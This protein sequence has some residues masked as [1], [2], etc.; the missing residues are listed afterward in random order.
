SLIIVDRRRR[1]WRPKVYASVIAGWIPV[2]FYLPFIWAQKGGTAWMGR[3]G[4]S[5]ILDPF[6]PGLHLYFA[7]SALVA[8]AVVGGAGRWNVPA[9]A[10]QHAEGPLVPLWPSHL[11]VLACA[12]L[13]VP[14]LLCAISWAGLPLLADR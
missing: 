5:A 11:L 10:D 7:L 8:L 14:Y 4:P 12:F 3:P 2:L 6:F 1:V 9:P 13:A